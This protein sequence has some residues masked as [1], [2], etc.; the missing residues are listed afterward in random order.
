MI[1]RHK[2][3]WFAFGAS[4]STIFSLLA[5]LLLRQGPVLDHSRVGFLV[6]EEPA[7]GIISTQ[8]VQPNVAENVGRIMRECGAV[9]FVVTG[10]ADGRPPSADLPLIPKN[11]NAVRCVVLR[12]DKE[13][14]LIKP[15]TRWASE[16]RQL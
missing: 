6:L 14:I 2:L 7:K 4:V 3:Q 13:K 8:P 1:R 15:E 10:P 12:S 16:Y 11:L 9:E 5:M